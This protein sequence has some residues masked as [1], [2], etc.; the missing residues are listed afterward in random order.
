MFIY[1]TNTD[2]KSFYFKERK[3]KHHPSLCMVNTAREGWAAKLTPVVF[4]SHHVIQPATKGYKTTDRISKLHSRVWFNDV[5]YEIYP[6][7]PA[8]GWWCAHCLLFNL[9]LFLLFPFHGFWVLDASVCALKQ[10]NTSCN[11]YP[12]LTWPI[13]WDEE[14]LNIFFKKNK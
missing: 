3:K 6:K 13:I 10:K 9:F 8:C 11:I 1:A 4:S 2:P 5:P 7:S 12:I 14:Q